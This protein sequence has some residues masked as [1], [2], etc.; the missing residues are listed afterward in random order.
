MLSHNFKLTLIWLLGGTIAFGLA[1]L[2]VEISTLHDLIVPNGPDSFYHAHRILTL[3]DTG[4][5]IQFDPL[6]NAPHG[7]YVSWPWAYDSLIALITHTIHLISPAT[8]SLG[9]MINLPPV[10]VF[11]NAGLIVILGQTLRLPLG[12][13]FIGLLCFSI[14]PLTQAL[15]MIGRLDHHMIELSFVLGALILGIRYFRGIESR[16]TAIAFGVLLG[17]APAFHNGLFIL[18]LPFLITLFVIWITKEE[19]SR[20]AISFGCA[21]LLS[22]LIF[23]LPSQP[24]LSGLF[25]Y[26]FHSWFHFYI[27]FC[28]CSICF[29]FCRFKF[30]KKSLTATVVLGLVLSLPIVIDIQGA[31]KFI[32][33]DDDTYLVIEEF[34]R[35]INWENS[36][37]IIPTV[38]IGEYSSL[39]LLLPFSVALLLYW[40]F[41]NR[42]PENYFF[43]ISTVFG[44][45]LLLAQ[46][47]L[48]YFGSFALYFPLLVIAS[49]LSK[50][51]QA[52]T[53]L[54][55][56]CLALLLVACYLP[57]KNSLLDSRYF[58]GNYD[59]E[60]TYKI[61]SALGTSCEQAPGTVLADYN[62]GH[63]ISFHTD[64]AVIA[65]NFLI[66]P[67][68]FDRVRFTKK[69]FD[70]ST[71]ELLENGWIGYVYIR[72]EDNIFQYKSVA[73][74]MGSNSKLVAE[75]LFSTDIPE[76][77]E[78]IS[79]VDFLYPN[80]E[81][82]PL[83]KA[84][85]INRTQ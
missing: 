38:N 85:K 3:L 74:A 37:G 84:F 8:S 50:R 18:Q 5:L 14:S 69:L 64:C 11:F 49:A 66:T 22:T 6:F 45:T 83:A 20:S 71:S 68:D 70:G 57:V 26:Y 43:V 16:N 30:N 52:A 54:I 65:N 1:A 72:R 41:I 15:H 25:S 82:Q 76:S 36:T 47:R 17:A 73:D 31:L 81:S 13:I 51:Y 61:Y 39:L 35:P 19:I 12:Y 60:M 9:T 2:H 4:T 67:L 53:K 28:T 79:S 42:R 44:A 58:G 59:Y 80:G 78:V 40:S 62:D 7:E 77:F 56:S 21:L 24:F 34:T 46:Y 48:N 32:T 29:Y 33:A 27:A 10:I 55:F 23:L 63:Y 75:L